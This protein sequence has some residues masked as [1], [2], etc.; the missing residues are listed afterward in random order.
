MK[1]FLK[2]IAVATG[3]N[4][5]LSLHFDPVVQE[6]RSRFGITETTPQGVALQLKGKLSWVI[7]D[8]LRCEEVTNFLEQN[9]DNDFLKMILEGTQLPDHPKMNCQESMLLCLILSGKMDIKTVRDAY[10]CSLADKV[11]DVGVFETLMGLQDKGTFV[12]QRNPIVV[13]D[14]VVFGSTRDPECKQCFHVG[15]CTAVGEDGSVQLMSLWNIPEMT[16]CSVDLQSFSR[17]ISEEQEDSEKVTERRLMKGT[18]LTQDQAQDIVADLRDKGF[19]DAEGRVTGV[20]DE[21]SIGKYSLPQGDFPE[22]CLDRVKAKLS[23]AHFEATHENPF[24]HMSVHDLVRI[25]RVNPETIR[26]SAL[27]DVVGVLHLAR[28]GASDSDVALAAQRVRTQWSISEGTLLDQIL[29]NKPLTGDFS[30]QD[31]RGVDLFGVD[32]GPNCKFEGCDFTNVR[33]TQSQ[34]EQIL[35]GDSRPLSLKGAILDGLNFKGMSLRDVNLSGCS[36]QD[37]SF[38]GVL[39]SEGAIFGGVSLT[40]DQVRALV[41]KKPASLKGAILTDIQFSEQNLSGVDFSGVTFQG[42]TCFQLEGDLT[43]VRFEGANTS[44]FE[45]HGFSGLELNQLVA[46]IHGSGGKLSQDVCIAIMTDFPSGFV[47]LLDVVK[48]EDREVLKEAFMMTMDNLADPHS[49]LIVLS[50]EP[51]DKVQD[52]WKKV[53]SDDR[54]FDTVERFLVEQILLDTSDA[55]SAKI[56]NQ[57]KVYLDELSTK[58]DRTM[59]EFFD[60]FEGLRERLSVSV[61]GKIQALYAHLDVEV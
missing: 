22:G 26:P 10:F 43:G 58:E 6:M 21:G 54:H 38:E 36:L 28:S 40:E 60:H 57:A 42:C 9:P 1:N 47:G 48:V 19:L 29:Q 59:G 41:D 55:D 53:C 24:K 11:G 3:P 25:A 31:F 16:F 45:L 49:L 56:I 23:G 20:V 35:S 39:S 46:F 32:F 4:S 5:R 8:S 15:I 30:S 52:F 61:F 13:G 12:T 33:L 17:L 18:G 44:G 37:A 34:L 14:M 51:F 50:G 27:S 2:M 7:T